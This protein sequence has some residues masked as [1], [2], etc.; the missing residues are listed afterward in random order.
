MFLKQFP[1]L[2]LEEPPR[3]SPSYVSQENALSATKTIGIEAMYS[4]CIYFLARL[5]LNNSVPEVVHSREVLRI[6]T[7]CVYWPR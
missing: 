4:A 7:R 3:F 1:P 6:F 5:E 2:L